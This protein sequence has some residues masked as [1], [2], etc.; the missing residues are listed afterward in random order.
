MPVPRPT[1]FAGQL[2]SL[3]LDPKAL[4]RLRDLDPERLRLVMDYMSEATGADCVD[5]HVDEHRLAEVT[6]RKRIAE[7]MWDEQMRGLTTAGGEPLFCDS[8]H[9]GR[10]RF[11]DRSD[12]GALGVWMAESYVDSLARA[13][14]KAHGCATCHGA[15]MQPRFLAQWG[16][17][18]P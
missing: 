1:R 11:L 4:P 7:R 16:A 8:C 9:Q 6:P 3:G 15:P 13:D 5:C 14:R 10:L 18:P 17:G 12:T 2:L